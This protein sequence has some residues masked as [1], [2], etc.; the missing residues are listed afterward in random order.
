MHLTQEHYL[1]LIQHGIMF[2]KINVMIQLK[3]LL[4]NI[5]IK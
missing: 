5:K 1:A 3:T 4:K 2:D